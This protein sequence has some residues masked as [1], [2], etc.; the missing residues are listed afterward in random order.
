MGAGQ[1]P[2]RYLM[3]E[4]ALRSLLLDNEAV[5]ALREASHPKHRRVLA[6]IEANLSRRRRGYPERV[7]VPTAV[8]VEA[9]W[10]RTDAVAALVNRLRAEDVPLGTATANAAAAIVSRLGVSLA[11]AHLGAVAQ[12]AAGDVVVLTSDPADIRRAADPKRVNA[13]RL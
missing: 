6:H 13:V 2:V 8:R 3:T 11:E 12:R 7:L 4:P 1:G 10:D 9:G 5:Q